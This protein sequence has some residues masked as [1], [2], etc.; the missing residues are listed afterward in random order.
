MTAKVQQILLIEDNPGDVYLFKAALA[1]CGAEAN[2]LV[3]DNGL[4]AW[5]HLEEV[6]Q[7]KK[8]TA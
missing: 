2:L 4:N 5:S 1:E 3:F 7:K 8:A 6:V